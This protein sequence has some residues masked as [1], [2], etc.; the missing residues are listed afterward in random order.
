MVTWE[1]TWEPT[2]EPTW[3]SYW[4]S[5]WE[6]L[7]TVQIDYRLCCMYTH[8]D[9]AYRDVCMGLRICKW[10]V[11]RNGLIPVIAAW[12]LHYYTSTVHTVAASPQYRLLVLDSVLG[13][14][15]DS[16]LDSVFERP[17]ERAM[18]EKAT[19][20]MDKEFLWESMTD[21]KL[22]VYGSFGQ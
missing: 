7:A 13:S 5:A 21:E 15:L 20:Q 12:C 3:E 9:T 11:P 6:T 14:Q 18:I 2:W 4:E 10:L 8:T 19:L 1:S 22:R 17:L 16:L